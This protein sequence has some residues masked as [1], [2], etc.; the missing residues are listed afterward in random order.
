MALR[1]SNRQAYSKPLLWLDPYFEKATYQFD[2]FAVI[3]N[4]NRF[5]NILPPFQ[6][7]PKTLPV[8]WV[9][10]VIKCSLILGLGHAKAATALN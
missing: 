2:V 7:C 4:M 10:S 1:V 9:R 3:I 6:T 5:D 8:R